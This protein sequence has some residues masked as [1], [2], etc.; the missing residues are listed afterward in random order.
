RPRCDRVHA[1]PARAGA[2]VR[3]RRLLPERLV[4]LPGLPAV[5]A[6]EEDAGR[7]ARIEMTVVLGRDDRPEPLERLLGSLRELDALGLLPLGGEIVGVEHLRPVERRR[8]TGEVAAAAGVTRRE[9]DGLTG[10]CA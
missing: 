9:L 7:A 3:P 4:Q 2:P 10:E 1:H 5:E 8:H 6:L